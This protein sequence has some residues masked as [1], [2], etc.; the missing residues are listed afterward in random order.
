MPF[1]GLP[2]IPNE[3]VVDRLRAKFRRGGAW[4]KGQAHIEE[5]NGNNRY[6]LIGALYRV[7]RCPRDERRMFRACKQVSKRLFPMRKP[8][9]SIPHF[10]DDYARNYRD[11]AAVL[12][13]ME[14]NAINDAIERARQGELPL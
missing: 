14:Q 10:N 13:Q 12:D 2:G 3:T 5:D 1:D 4:C 11:I 9:K 7:E 8:P 6:C